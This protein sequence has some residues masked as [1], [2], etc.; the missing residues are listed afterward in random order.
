M[1]SEAS[2]V[3]LFFCQISH[4]NER[5][6]KRG[7]EKPSF[8]CL[9]LAAS[10]HPDKTEKEKQCVRVCVCVCVCLNQ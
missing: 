10:C 3:C 9:L 8:S 5:A 4:K 1:T 7:D 2:V 6:T